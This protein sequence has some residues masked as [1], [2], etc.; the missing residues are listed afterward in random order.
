MNLIEQIAYHIELLGFGHVATAEEDGDI[1][2]GRMPDQ[3]DDCIV[4]MSTDSAV[5]GAQYG[6]RIQIMNRAKST[7][8]AYETSANLAAELDGFTGFLKGDGDNATIEVE[9]AACGI[10]PDTKKRE[11]Y[12]T[13]IR[14]YYCT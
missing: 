13:N 7:R 11:M 3:P 10:G 4:V 5:P 6:A 1:Y 9:N 12:S 14:V 8:K 2:W